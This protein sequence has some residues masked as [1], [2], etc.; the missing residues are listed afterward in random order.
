VDRPEDNGLENEPCHHAGIWKSPK[1]A[2]GTRLEISAEG[3]EERF[4]A[5]AKPDVR[6]LRVVSR[7]AVCEFDAPSVPSK[8]VVYL[9]EDLFEFM[10]E[11][12][13]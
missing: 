2:V 12:T 4:A 8:A 13:A 9:P 6:K 11:I 7:A 3:R 5:A 1:A 10:Y